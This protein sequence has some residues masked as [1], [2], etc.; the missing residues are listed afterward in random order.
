M[1]G[2]LKVVVLY[3]AGNNEI[4][5]RIVTTRCWRMACLCFTAET[6][7]K[8]RE[9][10]HRTCA[11]LVYVGAKSPVLPGFRIQVSTDTAPSG[12]SE[13]LDGIRLNSLLFQRLFLS[14]AWLENSCQAA[15]CS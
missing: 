7:Q 5:S 9:F 6:A 15:S 1:G 10:A 8:L 4:T 3:K 13:A 2:S 12:I 14:E 11:G